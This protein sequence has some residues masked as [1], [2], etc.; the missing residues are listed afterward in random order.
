MP[1]PVFSSVTVAPGTT[2]P[3]GS[4]TV[5]STTEVSNCALAA[6]A[7]Q[8]T[9]VAIVESCFIPVAPVW[10]DNKQKVSRT[11]VRRL[12]RIVNSR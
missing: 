11:G 4:R 2:L 5:P 6:K 8:T 9:S 12:Y 7:R 3:D 10:F 1:V